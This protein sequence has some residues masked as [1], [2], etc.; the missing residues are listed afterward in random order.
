MH[1]RGRHEWNLFQALTW[2]LHL[3]DI[4]QYWREDHLQRVDMQCLW[5]VRNRDGNWFKYLPLI[6]NWF[7][8][9]VKNFVP[10]ILIGGIALTM[11]I[12]AARMKTRVSLA[13]SLMV[14]GWQDE[15]L[16]VVDLWWSTTSKMDQDLS[17]WKVCSW[18][19]LVNFSP[20]R[21][22]AFSVCDNSS[23]EKARPLEISNAGTRSTRYPRWKVRSTELTLQTTIKHQESSKNN[24]EM[25]T[26]SNSG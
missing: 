22:P 1:Q 23:R 26:T 24:H 2:E 25:A 18:L 16:N 13:I 21:L 10:V 5:R 19:P 11:A 15:G 12:R 6:K 8:S 9:L 4:E 3:F 14:Q 17:L 20:V 7:P